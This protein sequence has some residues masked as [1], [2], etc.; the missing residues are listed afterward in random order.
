QAF[1][2]RGLEGEKGLD[3][4]EQVAD[5]L[6]QHGQDHHQTR[7]GG[8][9]GLIFPARADQQLVQHRSEEHTS[10]LQSRFDLVCRLLLENKNNMKWVCECCTTACGKSTTNPR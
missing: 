10:E 6:H 2:H 3:G 8:H 9:H 1:Q 7:Q 4:H 5:L